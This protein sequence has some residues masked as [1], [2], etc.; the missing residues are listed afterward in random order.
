MSE[1]TLMVGLPGSGKSTY[2]KSLQ[3]DITIVLYSDAISK[4][5]WGDENEQK[6]K[7]IVFKTLYKRARNLLLS[8]KNVIIDATNI[9]KLD[10]ARSLN[11]FADL[12]IK[13]K[14]IIIDT[15]IDE[16]IRR[17]QLRERKVPVSVIREFA[18]KYVEPT[19]EEGFDEILRIKV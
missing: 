18:T 6:N 16:C 14:A 3:N 15:P 5:L 12:N 2:A 8:G 1:L 4:E 7:D 11:R 13:R 17:N 9:L 10:R 19:L